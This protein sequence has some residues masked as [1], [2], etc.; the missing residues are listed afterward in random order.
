MLYGGGVPGS[1]PGSI[2]DAR[3]GEI[4]GVTFSI[5]G[6]QRLAILCTVIGIGGTDVKLGRGGNKTGPGHALSLGGSGYG[7]EC[8]GASSTRWISGGASVA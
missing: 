3:A 4:G 2:A 1:V 7:V 8:I 6:M 5:T